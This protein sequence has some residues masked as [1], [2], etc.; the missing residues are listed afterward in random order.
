[1]F[2]RTAVWFGGNSFVC[3][4]VIKTSRSVLSLP[5]VDG[6]CNWTVSPSRPDDPAFVET[7]C[8]CGTK[9]ELINGPAGW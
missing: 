1:M 5:G 8:D 6:D 7:A 9:C 3:L 2:I 4:P